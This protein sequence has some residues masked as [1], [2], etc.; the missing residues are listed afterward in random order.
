VI[1]QSNEAVAVIRQCLM[2]LAGKAA[3]SFRLNERFRQYSRFA[4]VWRTEESQMK[5]V[6]FS[7]VGCLLLTAQGLAQEQDPTIYHPSQVLRKLYHKISGGPHKT[8]V[9]VRSYEVCPE[10]GLSHDPDDEC[11]E[12]IAVPD[13]VTGKKR[14]FKSSIHYE[15][16]VVAEVRYR[17]KTK[18]IEKE[19]PAD[20]DEPACKTEEGISPSNAQDWTTSDRCEGRVY[21]ESTKPDPDAVDCKR[22][23]CQPGQTTIKIRYKSCVKEPYTVYRQIKRPIAIKQ[24]CYAEVDVPIT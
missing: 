4:S 11:I 24:P 10:C 9:D 14:M 13:C 23:E 16:V 3:N 21:C 17:W 19:V 7:F 22:I 5:A 1:S 18:W 2:C 20:F 15:Y 12:R 8:G 6:V